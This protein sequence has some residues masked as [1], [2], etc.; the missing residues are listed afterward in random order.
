ML[1]TGATLGEI[2]KKIGKNK[3]SVSREIARNKNKQ[4]EYN[5]WGAYV[6]YTVRRKKSVRKPRL[7]NEKLRSF[8][9]SCLQKSWSPEIITARWKM[10]NPSE[11][12]SHSTLYRAIKQKQ[13]PGVSPKTHLRRRGK[14]KNKHNSQS[15]KPVHTI[16]DRPP[17][18][19]T[20]SRPGDM[21]GDTVYGSIG[22]SCLVTAVDRTSRMLYAARCASRESTL[23]K[24]AFLNAFGETTV[25]SLTLD[26]GSEFAKFS[27]LE[28]E[29]NATVYFAQPRSPWQR[30]SVENINGLLRF[31]FP[32]GTN[33]DT[34]SDDA[35]SDVIALINNRPRKCLAWLSPVESVS[36][37]RC[38]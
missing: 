12:L 5:P 31:F 13:L 32:K 37:S 21:E 10:E 2:A 27:E 38:T 19:E 36:L 3:S 28:K 25:H 33:F 30:G 34:V 6:K 14:R 4:G 1:D 23:V 35:L 16:F 20:R 8:A 26:N 11:Q 18:I 24:E 9:V 17:I 15:I 29:L 22:K 7:A